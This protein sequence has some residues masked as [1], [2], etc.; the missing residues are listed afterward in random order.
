LIF[1]KEPAM[2][3]LNMLVAAQASPALTSKIA[4]TLQELTRLHLKKDPVLMAIAVQFVA[5]EQWFV[6]GSSLAA[7]HKASFWLDIKVTDAT[8]TKAEMA[9]YIAAVYAA[10]GEL[11]GPLHHE[12][13]VLVHPVPA[14]AYGY[15][16]QTQE[17]R[18]VDGL[19]PP[20][21]PGL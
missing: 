4:A 15:G 14:S 20:R 6:G 8:N 2:P 21:S 16:G 19:N 17:R 7:Q 5:R 13:Y 18:Y 1:N 9:A 12:S 11:L 10:F 3:F